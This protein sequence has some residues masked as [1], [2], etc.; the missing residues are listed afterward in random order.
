M[1]STRF[2]K[3]LMS[4]IHVTRF[5]AS[6]LVMMLAST[7]LMFKN[8]LS[9]PGIAP[10][11]APAATPPRNARIQISHGAT[12]LD[13]MPSAMHSDTSVPMR[14]WPGAP[15]LNRPVLNATATDRPVMMSG[16]ARKSMLPKFVEL[17]PHVSTPE[18]VRPVLNRPAN[19][20]RKPSQ[21][22][23]AP[24]SGF[25]KPT[26]AMMTLPTTRPMR[27]DSSDARIFLVMSF[28]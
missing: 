19:T 2:L 14:Y 13:G 23:D 22:L 17:K 20:R 6:Q 11:T 4:N 21:T 27:I 28:S 3:L 24:S 26:A 18:A 25:E 5:A 1:F 7:S 8:A 9:A 15:M 12:L 16:V 10:Q